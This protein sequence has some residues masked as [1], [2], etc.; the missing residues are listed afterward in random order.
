MS[1][2]ALDDYI[3]ALHRDAAAGGRVA[4]DHE[5][6]AAAS[7]SGVLA[8]V[9]FNDDPS[10]HHVFGQARTRR[11]MDNNIGSVV[12]AGT[13]VSDG[14]LDIDRHLRGYTDRHCVMAARVEDVKVDIVTSFLHPVHGAVKLPQRGD[15]QI[16]G[17]HRVKS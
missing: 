9:A 14:A 13:V 4:A 8:G 1:D 6:P 10:R 11:T 16:K 5:Q 7:R 15:R 2:I 3:D 12:H 17:R